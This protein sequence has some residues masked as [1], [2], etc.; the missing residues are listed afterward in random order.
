MKKTASVIVATA[1]AIPMTIKATA[2]LPPAYKDGCS[3]GMSWVYRNLLGKLPAWEGC[4]DAHDRL[5]GPGGTSDERAAA[6][7]GLYECVAASGH[8]L[9]AGV[10]WATVKVGGQPFFPFGWR[11]GFDKDYSTSWWYTRAGAE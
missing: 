6:D 10:M 2:S 11:W 9:I 4:C 3:G 7:S 5:Y 8:T 1:L